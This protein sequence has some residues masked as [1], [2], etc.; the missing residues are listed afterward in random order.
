M[1]ARRGGPRTPSQEQLMQTLIVRLLKIHFLHR[2][3]IVKSQQSIIELVARPA[4]KEMR[5]I[6]VSRPIIK[7]VH[8][9]Q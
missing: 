6:A 4:Q 1:P 9:R 8:C 3:L 5:D 2:S 7:V